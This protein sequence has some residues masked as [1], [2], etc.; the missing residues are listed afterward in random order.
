[1][2][3]MKQEEGVDRKEKKVTYVTWRNDIF[4]SPFHC[5]LVRS[6]MLL[7]FVLNFFKCSWWHYCYLTTFCISVNSNNMFQNV[8]TL[9]TTTWHNQCLDF[10]KIWSKIVLMLQVFDYFT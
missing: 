9:I 4:H 1:M 8:S 3:G 2:V 10:Q 7:P 5:G 6:P